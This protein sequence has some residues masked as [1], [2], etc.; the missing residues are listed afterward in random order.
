M[1]GMAL[2]CGALRL[3]VLALIG[4]AA[5]GCASQMSGPD[6]HEAMSLR[7]AGQYDGQWIAAVPAQGGCHF[8]S[9][10]TLDVHEGAITGIAINPQGR[11]P[12]RGT[13]DQTGNGNFSIGEF[14]GSIRF[15]N[16]RFTAEY[17]NDCG[18]RHAEGSKVPH[19]LSKDS[20]SL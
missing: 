4:V 9:Q 17:A 19:P 8:N 13:I 20:L 15:S 12:L 16:D 5:A 2:A 11:F 1:R 10:L 6:N 14:S 18:R 7:S 3:A